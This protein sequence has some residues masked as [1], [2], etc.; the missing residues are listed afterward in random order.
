MSDSEAAK[1]TETATAKAGAPGDQAPTTKTDEANDPKAEK[2]YSQSE[3]DKLVQQG[4]ESRTKN[5]KEQIEKE[6]EGEAEKQRLA[7][8]K[9]NGDHEAEL[10]VHRERANKAEAEKAVLALKSS[11]ADMLTEKG[12]AELIPLFNHDNSTLEGRKAFADAVLAMI[13]DKVKNAGTEKANAAR[14]TSGQVLD[15]KSAASTGAAM[16][17]TMAA[18]KPVH[19][20]A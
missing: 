9:A 14:T 8:A 6:L 5:I 19:A 11:T 10:E 13:E 20:H 3:A 17:P 7:T 2:L 4:I 15:T 1:G 12:A 16:Y 18:G